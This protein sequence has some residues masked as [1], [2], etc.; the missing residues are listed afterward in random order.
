[1]NCGHTKIYVM[2]GIDNQ[3]HQWGSCLICEREQLRAERDEARAQLKAAQEQLNAVRLDYQMQEPL[4]CPEC[5]Y[6]EPQP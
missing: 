4:R 2:S 5:G 6:E 3:P 1:M